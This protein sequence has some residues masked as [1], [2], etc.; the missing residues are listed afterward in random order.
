LAANKI[1]SLP[2]S[3]RD[4]I[5]LHDVTGGQPAQQPLPARPYPSFSSY[6]LP[7]SS[8]PLTLHQG[9]IL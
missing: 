1:P 6:P 4:V 7:D 8:D 2:T 3:R 5:P 9:S